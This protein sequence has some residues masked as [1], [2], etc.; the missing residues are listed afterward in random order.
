MSA[1]FLIVQLSDPHIGAEWA[2]GDPVVGLAAAVQSMRAIQL[3]PDVVLVTGDLADTAS[4]SEY[5]RVSELLS[6]LRAPVHVVPGN[7]DDRETLRRHFGLPGIAA[8]PVFYTID[9][10]P[11]RLVTLD[12]TIPGEAS[13]ALDLAQ[14]EWLDDVLTASPR[15]PTLVAMHHP[16]FLTGLPAWDQIGLSKDGRDLLAEVVHRHPQVRRIVAGHVHRTIAGELGGRSALSVPS[17]YA[18]GR[19]RFGSSQLEFAAEPAGFAVHAVFDLD[20]VSFIQPVG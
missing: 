6:P 14:L 1:P 7:H 12:T 11:L 10:G 16:P 18:Q 4:D 17:T 13:G 19:L 3:Q 2:D 9:L 15:Q 20:L 5:M 8:Q